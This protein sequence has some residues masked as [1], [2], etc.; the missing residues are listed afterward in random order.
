M[1]EALNSLLDAYQQIGE[2][3]PQLSQ[4]Q[5]LFSSSSHMRTAL[6]MIFQDILEFHREALGYFKRRSTAPYLLPCSSAD[7]PCRLGQAFSI[8]VEGLQL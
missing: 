6:F 2:Q 5:E 4:Y 7:E 8:I 1:S 3:I